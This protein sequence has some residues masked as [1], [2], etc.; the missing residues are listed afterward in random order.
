VYDRP[1]KARIMIAAVLSFPADAPRYVQVTDCAEH[2]QACV[3]L[4]QTAACQ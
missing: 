2:K 4:G 3:D 1:V